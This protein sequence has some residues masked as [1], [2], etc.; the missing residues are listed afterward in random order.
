MT[1]KILLL[2]LFSIILCSGNLIGQNES[3]PEPKYRTSAGV[4]LGTHYQASAKCFVGA[5][6]AFDVSLGFV[7]SESTP[8]VSMVFEYHHDTNIEEIHWY[9]G[10]GPAMLLNRNRNEIGFSA[11]LGGEI[12]TKDK[13]IN[14]FLEVQPVVTTRINNF[15]IGGFRDFNPQAIFSAGARYI[16]SH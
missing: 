7:Y 4:K 16:F 3:K 10:G 8:T 6:I 14:I 1:K 15:S 13:L 11:I 9:Y 12:V 5:D 2:F